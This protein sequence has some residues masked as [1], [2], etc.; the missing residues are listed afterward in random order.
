MDRPALMV[1]FALE[2]GADREAVEA[3]IREQLRRS[4]N[5][6]V[7]TA[8]ED[9]V[10]VAVPEVLSSLRDAGVIIAASVIVVKQSR[11]L[12]A[13]LRKLI[14]ETVRGIRGIKAAVVETAAMQA[15]VEQTTAE[16]IQAQIDRSQRTPKLPSFD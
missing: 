16:D 6:Q 8:V 9:A 14:E 5:V 4:A 2:P 13:E 11:E 10:R 12:G 7:E 1:R 3:A 15:P